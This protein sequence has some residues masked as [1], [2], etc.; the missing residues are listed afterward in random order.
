[1]RNQEK[2]WLQVSLHIVMF[3]IDMLNQV[4]FSKNSKEKHGIV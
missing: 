4:E 2:T 3:F 1:M